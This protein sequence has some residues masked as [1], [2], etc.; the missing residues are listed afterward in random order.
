MKVEENLPNI[1]RLDIETAPTYQPDNFEFTPIDE[2][3][4]SDA[5]FD[6]AS[7][8]TTEEYMQSL[9]EVAARINP[10]TAPSYLA[11]DASNQ[12]PYK[13]QDDLTTFDGF[14]QAFTNP[15][16]LENFSNE[17]IPKA[18][19]SPI[20]SGS[21]TSG[22]D[23]IAAHPDFYK[24]GWNPNIDN[25]S[26]YNANTSGWSDFKRSWSYWADSV[27]TGFMS[28]YRSI[29]DFFTDASYL[30][31]G[32]YKSALEFAEATRMGSS[33][34]GGVSGFSTNLFL[35]SGYT[36]G[37]ISNIMAEE[38]AL[39]AMTAASGFSAAPAAA[40]RTGFNATRLGKA[41]SSFGRGVVNSIP[42]ARTVR[43]STDILTTL[44]NAEKAKNFWQ[45]LRTAGG[46]GARL[47]GDVL[48]PELRASLKALKTGEN[49][50]QGLKVLAKASTYGGFYR[51]LRSINM[52][53]SEAK[54]EGGLAYDDLFNK[55]LERLIA[56]NDGNTPSV[57]QLEEV[58]KQ[59]LEAAT[60]SISF[61]A[62]LIYFTN[63]I[64]LGRA[65]SGFSPMVRRMFSKNVPGSVKH[66]LR[67][68]KV[69]GKDGKVAKKIFTNTADDKTILGS[70]I[71]LN[72]LKAIGVKGSIAA[73]GRGLLRYSAA[74]LGEGLQEVYQEGVAAGVS[75]Y[76]T[77]LLENPNM[78][79]TDL[80]NQAIQTAIDSQMSA[81][82]VEVFMSGFLMGGI[83]QGPQR[84]LFEKIPQIIKRTTDPE[85]FKKFQENLA[86]FEIEINNIADRIQED[87]MSY[88]DPNGARMR[89]AKEMDAQQ[90]AERSALEGDRL[91][92]HD[93]MDDAAFQ[94]RLFIMQNGT[95]EL[96]IQQL[97]DFLTLDDKTLIEAFPQHEEAIKSGK[98]RNRIQDN[99]NGLQNFQNEYDASF[100]LIP[101]SPEYKQYEKNTK[102]YNNARLKYAAL[103]HARML[104]LFSKDAFSQAVKRRDQLEAALQSS[105]IMEKLG[106]N[107]LTVLLDE[108]NI[109]AELKTLDAEIKALEQAEDVDKE[110]LKNK[111]VK[112][113]TLLAY[114]AALK[115]IKDEKAGIYDREKGKNI[116]APLLAYLKLLADSNGDFIN[117]EK[118]DEVIAQLLDH[119]NLDRRAKIY[120]NV[121]ALF[122]D[123]KKF[124]DILERISAAHVDLFKSVKEKYKSNVKGAIEDAAISQLLEE[125]EKQGIYV[126]VDQIMKF[127][128]SKD[129]KD[130]E[131]F[132][133]EQG[134]LTPESNPKLFLLKSAMLGQYAAVQKAIKDAEENA[135]EKPKSKKAEEFDDGLGGI[136]LEQVK[137]SDGLENLDPSEREAA[138]ELLNSIKETE[139]P[140]TLTASPFSKEVLKSLYSMYKIRE[141]NLGNDF[142]SAQEWAQSEEGQKIILALE[143]TKRLWWKTLLADSSLTK[144]ERLLIYKE[145]K[146]FQKW[147]LDNEENEEVNAILNMYPGLTW[148]V[149]SGEGIISQGRDSVEIEMTEEELKQREAEGRE[150]IGK[151]KRKW[152]KRERGVN[153]LLDVI[154]VGT[155]EEMVTYVFT[156]NEGNQLSD[157][158]LAAVGIKDGRRVGTPENLR[159]MTKEF[160]KLVDRYAV[161]QKF[162]FGGMSLDYLEEI[163]GEIDGESGTFIVLG[164]GEGNRSSDLALLPYG[165]RGLTG[166][167]RKAAIVYVGETSFANL[168][169]KKEVS[170]KDVV[171]ESNM[172]KINPNDINGIYPY[173]FKNEDLS[174]KDLSASQFA[175]E[176][177]VKT[178]ELLTPEELNRATVVITKNQQR[179]DPKDFNEDG[180]LGN[181]PANIFIKDTGDKYGI[182]LKLDND[183]K[184]R[185]QSKLKDSGYDYPENWQG[186]IGFIRNDFYQFFDKTNNPVDVANLEDKFIETY[187]IGANYNV[188]EFRRAYNVQRA[189]IQR[190]DDIMKSVDKQ[191]IT[192]GELAKQIGLQHGITPGAFQTIKGNATPFN[193]LEYTTFDGYKVWVVKRRIKKKNGKEEFTVVYQTDHPLQG[194]TEF[195]E[196]VQDELRKTKVKG[197]STNLFDQAEKP[198]S[199]SYIAVVKDPQGTITLVQ[200]R[201]R[202]LTQEERAAAYQE[203]V[204]LAKSFEEKK[205]TATTINREIA[206]LYFMANPSVD[207]PARPTVLSSFLD[208]RV[209]SSK[210]KD[211]TTP[212][213]VLEFKY[214]SSKIREKINL[215]DLKS[216]EDIGKLFDKLSNRA[217]VQKIRKKEGLNLPISEDNIRFGFAIGESAEKLADSTTTDSSTRVR[218]GRRP[219][220][221]AITPLASAENITGTSPVEP[222][223]NKNVDGS[224]KE[225]AKTSAQKEKG[226]VQTK[227]K[228]DEGEEVEDGISE[229]E[230][231]GKEIA[232]LEAEKKKL[233]KQIRV[234]AKKE[235]RK[236]SELKA[237][238]EEYK[239]VESELEQLKKEQAKH[240]GLSADKILTAEE[241][242]EETETLEEF[243]KWAEN[244]LPEF[245]SIGDIADLKGRMRANGITVG[246]FTMALRDLAGNLN[247]DGTIYTG[248]NQPYRYHEAFH[249]VYRLLLTDKEQA[250]LRRFAKAEKLKQFGSLAEYRQDIQRFKALHPKYSN[251]SAQQLEDLYLEEY[252]ADEFNKFKTNPKSTKTN[253]GIKSF[254]NRIVEIIKAII[255]GFERNQLLNLFQKIDSGKYR[256][257]A[258]Q[259]N[260]FVRSLADGVTLDANKIIPH[261]SITIDGKQYFE[262]LDPYMTENL[263]KVI[264]SLYIQKMDAAGKAQQ[265]KIDAG[266][267]L[268]EIVTDREILSDIISDLQE[269]YDTDERNDFYAD[270]SENQLDKLEKLENAV[271]NYEEEIIEATRD[272]L[273]SIRIKL[274][275]IEDTDQDTEQEQGTVG[276]RNYAL[277]ASQRGG[278]SSMTER[279]RLFIGG[280]TIDSTDGFGNTH[281]LDNGKTRIRVPVNVG[282]VYNG[283]M[284]AGVH[285]DTDS[286]MLN[287]MYIYSRRNENSRAVIDEFFNR[288]GVYVEDDTVYI[289]ETLNAGSSQL[290]HDFI[291]TF[292]NARFDYIL[293]LQDS[294][295]LEVGF[296]SAFTADAANSQMDEW[297]KRFGDVFEQ[298]ATDDKLLNRAISTLSDLKSVFGQSTMNNKDLKALAL[299][300]SK[301]LDD[302]L[303][304]KL[305]PLYLEVS[306]ASTFSG[307][308]L[309]KYATQL[310]SLGEGKRLLTGLAPEGS[311]M[312]DLDV[313][314]DLLSRRQEDKRTPENFF[315]NDE[316]KG[317][318][319]RL[320]EIAIGNASFDESV[321]NTVFKNAE[322]QF[323]H[324]HQKQTWHS[325]AIEEWN[326]TDKTLPFLSQD[327]QDAF[328]AMSRN[329]QHHI[330]RVAGL[331]TAKRLDSKGVD[332]GEAT[333][334]ENFATEG[335]TNYGS[336]SSFE[337]ITLLMNLYTLNYNTKS[338]RNDSIRL[339]D[340]RTIA[341]SP[342]LIRIM[343]SA[344]N[345]DFIDMGVIKTIDAN[346]EITEEALDGF[347][348]VVLEEFTRIRDEF[349]QYPDGNGPIMDYNDT[350]N[351][352]AFNFFKAFE[353]LETIEG[354]PDLRAELVK[355]AKEGK[356]MPKDMISPVRDLIKTNLDSMVGEL[357]TLINE[358]VSNH[359]NANLSFFVQGS[360]E[361]NDALTEELNLLPK[362]RDHNIKQIFLNNFL[363]TLAV[364]NLLHGDEA[365]IF[366]DRVVN[367]IKRAKSFNNATDSVAFENMPSEEDNLGI[368]TTLGEDS[369]VV[370]TIEDAKFEQIFGGTGDQADAQTYVTT[371]GAR[372]LSYGLGALS[373]EFAEMLDK[374]EE[375]TED[376]I[377][378]IEKNFFNYYLPGKAVLNS[379]KYAY[380]DGETQIKTSTVTLT[381]QETSYRDKD[382]NIKPLPGDALL[383]N[384]RLKMEAFEKASGYKKVAILAPTSASKMF[385]SNVLTQSEL[386][387]PNAFT[388]DQGHNLNAKFFGRQLINPSNKLVIPLPTQIKALLSSEQNDKVKVQ[389]NGV[390][391]EIGKIREEYHKLLGAG[392]QFDYTNKFKLLLDIAGM[393]ELDD[394]VLDY[395]EASEEVD[396]NLV[397]FIKQA[398]QNLKS[399]AAGS[400][401]MAFF[402]DLDGSAKYELNNTITSDK[403]EEF[404]GAYFSKKILSQKTA[405]LTLA[406]KSDLGKPIYR[407]VYSLESDGKLDK[408]K[409]IR[410]KNFIAE[411]LEPQVDIR[412]EEGMAE[413]K[414]LLAANPKD[415][416]IV[417]DRLRFD[418]P[419]YTNTEANPKKW[420][421]TDHRYSEMLTSAHFEDV[422]KHV[423][424]SKDDIPD[425]IAKMFAVRVPSQDKHSSMALKV[426]DFEPV[427]NGSTAVF[428]YELIEISGADFDIDKVF[429]SMKEWYYSRKK[430][431]VEYGS[432]LDKL[433]KK[434]DF[435]EAWRQYVRYSNEKVREKN[436]YLYNAIFKATNGQIDDESLRD[437]EKLEPG[438]LST[439]AYFAA[440]QLNLPRDKKEFEKYYEKNGYEPYKAAIDNKLLDA[441][442]SLQANKGV[443]EGVNGDKPIAHKPADVKALQDLWE[444]MSADFPWLN[445]FVKDEG[446]SID[447]IIGQYHSHKS[448]KENSNMIGAVVPPNV[449]INFL[450]EMG[451]EINPDFGSVEI[452]EDYF[453]DMLIVDGINL[454]GEPGKPSFTNNE[455]RDEKQE[456]AQYLISNLVTAATDDAKERLLGKLG[457]AKK[458]L[459]LL[460]VMLSIG[461]P[462][463]TG[464]Y[465][466]NIPEVRMVMTDPNSDMGDLKM[467]MAKGP[468]LQVEQS[469]LRRLLEK[470]SN[471]V[472]SEEDNAVLNGAIRFLQVISTLSGFMDEMIAISNLS[473][474]FG[475]NFGQLRDKEESIERLG[476]YAT[477]AAFRGMKYRKNP[478]PMDLRNA[479][480]VN[481]PSNEMPP[482]YLGAYL[483]V[484]KHFNETIIPKVFASQ[485]PVFKDVYKQI[486]AYS[487]I[488]GTREGSKLKSKINKDIL[489]YFTIKAYMHKLQKNAGESRNAEMLGSLSNILVYSEE[490]NDVTIDKIIARLRQ[491]F[492]NQGRRNYFLDF[493]AKGMASDALGNN[494][495]MHV[496]MSNSF[497]RLSENEKIRIQNGF[498]EIYFDMDMH[499][500]AMHIFHYVMVKDGLQYQYGSLLDAFTPHVM[501]RYLRSAT[502]SFEALSGKRSFEDVFGVS[503]DDLKK[504]IV[505]NY[506]ESASHANNLKRYLPDFKTRPGTNPETNEPDGSLIA[507]LDKENP[508]GMGELPMFLSQS[509]SNPLSSGRIYYRL[510]SATLEGEDVLFDSNNG[511]VLADRGV[512][513]QF[514]PLG[515]NFQTPIAFMFDIEGGFQ[516]P[517][518]KELR[519][520]SNNKM[521]IVPDI[522]DIT[523]PDN[524]AEQIYGPDSNI[525]AQEGSIQVNGENIADVEAKLL[526]ATGKGTQPAE[527]PAEQPT[528]TNNPAEFT[529]HSGGAIGADSM[530]DKI[531]KEYGQTEHKHYY[532]G[533]KTPMGNVPLTQE[534]VN[535]GIEKAKAAAQQ[536]GRSWNDKYGSLLGRNWF[537]VKNSDQVIAIAP[538][539]RPGERGSKG[540]VSKAKRAVV[541]GGTGYAVEMAIA[542]GKAVHVFNTND[543]SWYTW[544]GSTFVKSEVPTLAKNFAGIGSRQNQGQMTQESI[545]AIRDVY[546]KTFR[547]GQP[548]TEDTDVSPFIED[549]GQP[550]QQQVT[551]KRNFVELEN[552]IIDF[553]PEV[554]ALLSNPNPTVEDYNTVVGNY[555]FDLSA[556]IPDSLRKDIE[557]KLRD[558]KNSFTIVQSTQPQ[559]NL[560][561]ETAPAG[562]NVVIDSA[563]GRSP[564]PGAVV[565]FRTKGKTE[566]N[567]IDALADNAVGNPFGPAAQITTGTDGEAVTR[568][569]NWLEGTG[570][571]DVMQDYRN[572]LLAK[573]PEL[574]GKT[575]FYY[576]DLGRPSHATALDYFLN[577]PTQ[578]AAEVTTQSYLYY[579][580]YYAIQIDENGRGI[581]VVGYKSKKANKEKL[582]AAFNN[583]PNVDPQTGRAFQTV[584]KVEKKEDSKKKGLTLDDLNE[585]QKKAYDE[586]LQFL[587]S[588]GSGSHSLIG[589]AGTGKTTLLNF[590]R[591]SIDI[592]ETVVF[593][594]PTHRANAVMKLK[595]PKEKV[596][597]LH[598]LLDLSPNL[599]LE[600]YDARNADFVQKKSKKT[601]V[602]PS[603]LIIDESSMINDKLFDLI[604]KRFKSTKILFVG[605]DAQLKPV[606]QTTVSKALTST[607]GKSVLNQVMRAD[608]SNLL[609]E[610]MHTREKG[611]YTYV[612]NLN[613]DDKGVEF[614]EQS[615]EFYRRASEM[616][617]SEEFNNNPLLLRILSFTNSEVAA[618]NEK[619]RLGKFG[620]EAGEYEVGDIIMGYSNW[621]RDYATEQVQ[622]ANGGDYKILQVTPATKQ[623][624]TNILEEKMYRELQG[625]N[626]VFQNLLNP[627]AAPFKAFVLSKNNSVE[628]LEFLAEV[629]ESV[630]Q[631][632]IRTKDGRY[633]AELDHFG[634]SFISP[635]NINYGGTTKITKTLDY[636]YA[637]TIHKSQGGTYSNIFI[638]DDT[639]NKARDTQLRSQL[640]YVAVTRAESKATVL[641]A[642][643]D[644]SGEF[645]NEDFREQRPDDFSNL[646][647]GPET[648]E[649]GNLREDMKAATD[650]LGIQRLQS[651]ISS[652]ENFDDARLR[653]AG[654]D[655]SDLDSLMEAYKSSQFTTTAEFADYI[656]KC[657]KKS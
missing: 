15:N 541:D 41:L 8:Q 642:G 247:V 459:K 189:L 593:S 506:G 497:G 591:D 295:T 120:N 357:L 538:I 244:N 336:L 633:F 137:F 282:S 102:E 108:R 450:K 548:S 515:S 277:D 92:F 573:V 35:Q 230:R 349:K 418:M 648:V 339:E 81:E 530:F 111:K 308:N 399:S 165:A 263:V 126:P 562:G 507:V 362:N 602:P 257:G 148:D 236:P 302:Q 152:I 125:L 473:Q 26:Y 358:D 592:F 77:K 210:E 347:F 121:V 428:P 517:N 590:V 463:K 3:L 482:H 619:M 589:Y 461:V 351:G 16:I 117:Q 188:E 475:K 561:T 411:G 156:D 150:D 438:V 49:S 537:Q 301:K 559:T 146:G 552:Q 634:K 284:M 66:F 532:H 279:M 73:T 556:D 154:S 274:Q 512:Y 107:D 190:I 390:S 495:N 631:M 499:S 168:F 557:S 373:P 252:M 313:M 600:D 153:I 629:Y 228:L 54:M 70:L 580:A 312:S 166:D 388:E 330:R 233:N 586:I 436:H 133:T 350:L 20:I 72:R 485:T 94:D 61:N 375:F 614:L 520:G 368:K 46:T 493:F 239:R 36:F 574:K 577:K 241:A 138:I 414:K 588:E 67:T 468:T 91:G 472:R 225:A 334:T 489:A 643:S 304:I 253:S 200:T 298:F 547:T 632:G 229:A 259:D 106:A 160:D 90:E 567:M 491:V 132:Y 149:I 7:T 569:L 364:N 545:Q 605:D 620:R 423:E 216:P 260:I 523:I 379:Q 467:M 400:N 587:Q 445:D 163:E 278:V 518:S 240:S 289:P 293:Q 115:G 53:M 521:V 34:R 193:D 604:Q 172:T 378:S 288:T 446:I 319:G 65:L 417:V 430:G 449:I 403:V 503:S 243:I 652:S 332:V 407:R 431:F 572:A 524:I 335:A 440:E 622:M 522:P 383:H 510:V 95:A 415:G 296:I 24:L 424:N 469:G 299:D 116:K 9:N 353:I 366:K 367:P 104:Y 397:M 504:E 486:L 462:L 484:F 283:L 625:F 365:R 110:L 640:R 555:E 560:G 594:S 213:I 2:I 275:N 52:A 576:K 598:S 389:I 452:A 11:T 69:I 276:F 511:T 157:E 322:G 550:T 585:G 27:G 355:L 30:K 71:G 465:I 87:P 131:E 28:G 323:I 136:D 182:A 657:Y 139:D 338:N 130:L 478:M 617:N 453:M 487:R 471:E 392:V 250:K 309:R 44:R 222:E 396:L 343:E 554:Q 127:L 177:L 441:Q 650:Q 359:F 265:A 201:P 33:T 443:S 214:G 122:S 271:N 636:G 179:R 570:D 194:R 607:D 238:S 140:Q 37:I 105:G 325:Q 371:H 638:L 509:D 291:N 539:V 13:P 29:G 599:D 47:I 568:F 219:Y 646:G 432:G 410:K 161:D 287:S 205:K 637:H 405:G 647:T 310:A 584:E 492:A 83:V 419:E 218:V 516:R 151:F 255:R 305:S 609:D 451:V 292:R 300:F 406:L 395:L 425:V 178:L 63:K 342:I 429:A 170:F 181:T 62:P 596:L 501:E 635:V 82:G 48:T 242:Q 114:E 603:I 173:R 215:K 113:T 376:S 141:H 174:G 447:S 470:G 32:D 385:K 454:R 18:A 164:Y 566:Q 185:I 354:G 155:D 401:L 477:D 391:V 346:S 480:G 248:V 45:G 571:T 374:I 59:A 627:N 93:A 540:F 264:G 476:L 74:S 78:R 290:Y 340:G 466:L 143:L 409:V 535:E 597:T 39:A 97:E 112:R 534:Q 618:A 196:R 328:D 321:G 258:I 147:L 398:R 80:Q 352:T 651:E 195:L 10:M 99:I 641:H 481:V 268:G 103:E 142:L 316:E 490:Q 270:L 88:L 262:Y 639:I 4:G 474:G 208:I 435:N 266:E 369:I 380:A 533:R 186:D 608:N 387:N 455:N 56:E 458:A 14:Q 564:Q 361:A 98:F 124:N 421:K 606:K 413:L 360:F 479:F 601:F 363:N 76:Y 626:V 565:A 326:K 624:G 582:L 1:P 286:D 100:D 184:N 526:A 348:N 231:I 158:M 536:L 578:P 654:I 12:I 525:E 159:E 653:D 448:V 460:E 217:E 382:G 408:Q 621:G 79:K 655:T 86:K 613:A 356:D 21:R 19:I 611:G 68:S 483:R 427:Y 575:I 237:E 581:D 500:D 442:F 84:V 31:T 267:E 402:E 203:I 198:S 303:G 75:E 191:D 51:D 256:G 180:Y 457:Y 416:V 494:T 433:G 135:K 344:N 202:V 85:G 544:D 297:S 171:V 370:F 281:L 456:R 327:S 404:F 129:I 496:A 234:Q 38:L 58:S 245:I 183:A 644:S 583:N 595:M 616:Y 337:F 324:A 498:Q 206:E 227:L 57:E 285:K 439:K 307:S 381:A 553:E 527:Q 207:N 118:L 294:S 145:D 251:L 220:I 254:F 645:N 437:E 311:K 514:I 393:Q 232:N 175:L 315:I 656:K 101:N 221:S 176:R 628:D 64:A 505:R 529:N 22:Y 43:T 187:I 502:E 209:Y 394:T 273:D 197:K 224:E 17:P 341:K 23:R 546:E 162:E 144:D 372:H 96:H 50:V 464:T 235:G 5:D 630:R 579:G 329:G 318:V 420:K 306:I 89:F 223:E 25:E 167:A 261:N 434:K 488:P 55:N 199:G 204:D 543:N 386:S 6:V 531:G 333:N 612:T 412:T 623:L 320:M 549:A 128:K 272:Y 384:L 615:A 513:R 40:A 192:F 528:S 551:L 317:M 558:V 649:L 134:L 42:F 377:R 60:T 123:G 280:I 444:E 246:T 563:K 211:V 422:L 345:G 249:A 508:L 119:N 519:K 331:R 269:L 109:N 542:E 169:S 610:S 426:V 314:I 212:D 226:A